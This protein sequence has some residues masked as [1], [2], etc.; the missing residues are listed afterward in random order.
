MDARFT[1]AWSWKDCRRTIGERHTIRRPTDVRPNAKGDTSTEVRTG[2]R[3]RQT[4]R[5]AS[6]IALRAM[7]ARAE[8][9]G[10]DSV[11]VRTIRRE[12]SRREG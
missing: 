6:T 2:A 5:A 10:I 1:A 7:L 8:A 12:V 11:E 3:L 4:V 9:E